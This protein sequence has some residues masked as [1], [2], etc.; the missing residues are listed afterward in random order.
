M[1]SPGDVL[2]LSVEKPVAGGR[3]IAR[4]DGRVVLVSGAIPGEQVAAKIERVDKSVAYAQT[5]VVEQPSPDRRETPGDSLC[6]GCLY[7]HIAYPRQCALKAAVIRDAFAR[8]GRL[9][10]PGAVAVAPS[11]EEGYRMRARLH[12]RGHRLGFF[13]ENTHDI[14]DARQTGQLLPAT[15]DVL[16]R[17]GAGLRSLGLVAGEIELAENLDASDRVVYVAVDQTIDARTFDKLAET[18]GLTG[19]VVASGW[20]GSPHVTDRLDLAGQAVALTR[21]VRAFFQG[22]RYLLRDL[23][24]HVVEQ[25]PAGDN[26]VDL[27]AGVG[28]FA[29]A[30]AISRG[31]TVIAVE[32]DLVAARDLQQNAAASGSVRPVRESV[33]VFL[34]SAARN[35]LFPASSGGPGSQVGTVI[36]DPPRTGMSRDA[37]QGVV[38]LGAPRV[39]YVSC[40]VATLARDARRL[41]DSGYALTRVDAF[42]LFPNTPHVETVTV[43][44]R[45]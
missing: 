16:D 27:Y 21:H 42:D 17:V 4:H 38:A 18:D 29:L 10:L 5:V 24:A 26:V 11:P 37:L 19:L 15:C 20:Y 35:V 32:G 23:A 45:M 31:A 34:S 33:E 22:N 14:C 3:M 25:V 1:P 8:L 36:V 30:A 41:V 40:D 12:V 44:T 7:A 13:R 2:T 9:E 6:G 28:L 43:F 39:V